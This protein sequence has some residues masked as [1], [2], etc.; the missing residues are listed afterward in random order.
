[1]NR[2]FSF[3][4]LLTAS[5]F[6]LSQLLLTSVSSAN[7]TSSYSGHGAGSISAEDLKAFTPPP[8][9]NSVASKINAMI[10]IVAPGAGMLHP[11]GKVLYFSWRISGNTQ[12]WK[13]NSPLSFPEQMTGGRD[14]TTLAD[15]TPDGRFL[16]LQRD[17]DGQEDPGIYLQKAEGGPLT[18]VFHQA[19]VQAHFQ[20]VTDDSQ[21]LYFTANNIEPDSFVIYRV[22]LKQPFQFEKPEAVF[23]EK[24][25]W[26]VSDYKDN[27]LLL[28]KATGSRTSENYTYDLKSKIKT[29]VIGIEKSEEYEVRFAAKKNEYLVMTPQIGDFRRLY[30][31]K[32]KT[33]K[34]LS[35]DIP[36]DVS[37]F[38]ID[39]KRT[40]ILYE[41]N[42]A[43]S[44]RLRAMDARNFKEISLPKMPE[45]DHVMMGTTTRDSKSTMITVV[46]ST[47]PRKSY[48]YNWQSKKLT[49]WTLPSSP[50]VDLSRFVRSSLETYTTRDGVKI[51]M[52]VRRPAQCK[53]KTC[54]VIVHFHG[55]PEGQSYPGFNTLAQLFVDEGFIFVDPNVRGSDGYG[56]TWLNSDNAAKRLEV[57]TDIEDCAKEI[58]SKWAFNGETPKIGVMGWSYGGYS[59]FMAMTRFAGA[60][61]SGVALVGMSDLVSFLNN[62]APYRRK[63][64]ATEYGDPEKDKEALIKLSPI[65]YLQQLKSP[66]MII[67]GANDPRVPAGEAL[68]I[69][70]QL[71]QK[72]IKSQLI[73]F[74]D[75]GHGTQKKENR[76]LEWGHTLNFFKETL[77]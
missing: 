19:K 31:L 55:G 70:K 8:L 56:K 11:N 69:H 38:S 27:L 73:L 44:T 71:R 13:I 16:I 21:W 4:S 68:Q 25:V 43:G 42:E 54:P 6:G 15:I 64:R 72:G 50:E 58:R 36:Y 59:T 29:P 76:I 57:I 23:S 33:L 34:P 77:K 7:P 52:F 51:P 18:P 28:S 49:Q 53:N 26:G 30:L 24:G 63:L 65:T 37:S 1:M 47:A 48:S 22:S 60:Y 45:T 67:Q 10:D 32:D 75:E 39:Q 14:A 46:T 2:N 17:K 20:F 66:L 35:V 74:P 61:D 12:V 62:T 41:I 5:L 40:R 9:P 3:Q